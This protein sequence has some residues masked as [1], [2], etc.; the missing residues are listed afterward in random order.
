MDTTMDTTIS[1][2]A[3]R[4]MQRII[5]RIERILHGLP[6]QE[7]NFI[8]AQLLALWIAS[9]FHNNELNQ[10][11]HP[12]TDKIREYLIDL[13]LHLVRNLIPKCE[14]RVL[15][16]AVDIEHLDQIKDPIH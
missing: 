14:K 7:Q 11:Q 10:D 13:H 12:E 2:F 4:R 6:P 5:V 15:E 16:H 1:K 8:L 3:M 9:H